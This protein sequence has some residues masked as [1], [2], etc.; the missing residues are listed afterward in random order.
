MKKLC[1]LYIYHEQWRESERFQ[2][3]SENKKNPAPRQ[4][5]RKKNAFIFKQDSF[6]KAKIPSYQKKIIIIKAKQDDRF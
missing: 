2:K 1:V 4:F 3:I 5:N 6:K